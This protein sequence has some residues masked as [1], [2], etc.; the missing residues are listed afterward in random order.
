MR[1]SLKSWRLV[2]ACSA[3]ALGVI[4][5]GLTSNSRASISKSSSHAV[6]KAAALTQTTLMADFFLG[7]YHAAFFIAEKKGWYQ[8]AGINVKYLTGTGSDNTAEQ[9]AS[10]NET[11]GL[12]G[13][14]AVVR[15]VAKGEQIKTV[16]QLVYNAGLC[17]VVPKN[18]GINSIKQLTGKT[19]ASAPG[20]L[21]SSLLPVIEKHAGLSSTAINYIPTTYTA[22]IPA[23]L[24]GRFDAIGG[25]DYGEILEA[26]F[27][28]LPSKCIPFVTNGAPVL[29]FG[30]ITSDSEIKNHPSVVKAFVQQTV[31]AWTYSFQHP[32]AALNILDHSATKTELEAL[33]PNK[34]NLQ[35]FAALKKDLV[36]SYP[37]SK[38][39]PEG[40][41]TAKSWTAMEQALK[42]G[43]N[44]TSILPASK[45]Y[46]NE[47]VGDCAS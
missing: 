19:Y 10:G 9:V 23:Y 31:R 28:G 45:L 17:V 12:A 47:F 35:G 43:G 34:V 46:T 42:A 16:A 30:L 20:S 6:G 4:G 14:D 21:T 8:Q 39:T 44:I 13:S 37:A 27:E 18:S 3:L 7:F 40:C 15:A 22:I 11:F 36:G 26:N 33:F 38:G 2:V 29:G 24:K 41:S 1:L 25:F 32:E 5:W